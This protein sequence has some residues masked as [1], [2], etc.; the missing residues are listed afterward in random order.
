MNDRRIVC[1]EHVGLGGLKVF[2]FGLTISKHITDNLGLTHFSQFQSRQINFFL[3]SN[4][5]TH[6]FTLNILHHH[7]YSSRC[8]TN[9]LTFHQLADGICITPYLT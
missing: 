3:L 9:I 7:Y 1:S 8:M 5:S 2:P 4:S 6:L